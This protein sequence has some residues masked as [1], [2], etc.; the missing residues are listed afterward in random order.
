MGPIDKFHE[1]LKLHNFKYD[2]AQEQAVQLIQNL[3]DELLSTPQVKPRWWHKIIKKDRRTVRGL[4]FWGGVGR[5]KTFLMDCFFEVLPFKN[6]RRIHFHRFM[7]DIHEQLRALPKTPNPLPIVAKLISKEVRVL[8]LDEFH[9]HDITDAMLLTGLF[10]SL[11]EY[12]VTLFATSNVK[13]NELYKNGLQRNL[14]LPTIDYLNINTKEFELCS[15][16]DFRLLQLEKSGTYHINVDAINQ[17]TEYFNSL[18]PNNSSTI[19]SITI[20]HRAMTIK[21]IANDVVWFDFKIICMQAHA[22]PD[23]LEIA[24]M[25]HTVFISDVPI[26]TESEDDAAKRF[27]HLIDALYDHKVKL[28]MSASV[29]PFELYTGKRLK[30]AFERTVSRLTEMASKKYLAL[31]HIIYN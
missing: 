31:P 13:I 25:F 16:E 26:L 24:Q 28:V 14:F 1:K 21:S 20:N 3:Y 6:K 18:A 9:V 12:G 30:F 7:I 5:G 11:F 27:I 22:A 8:C 10:K 19:D 4:Y 29:L 15:N 2:A 17:M 23:Y